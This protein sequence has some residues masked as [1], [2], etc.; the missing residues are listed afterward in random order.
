[1]RSTPA[2]VFRPSRKKK[3]RPGVGAAGVFD[4]LG[5]TGGDL[6][7]EIRRGLPVKVL[8]LLTEEL[9]VSQQTLLKVV[10]LPSA[11]LARR[12]RPPGRLSPQESDRVYRVAAAYRAALQL[13]EGD[14]ET[15]RRWMSEP[16][17]ALGGNTPI[18]HLDTEA[19]AGEVQDLIGRLEHGVIT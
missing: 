12:R 3:R 16:A 11:T 15:A 6:V 8:D 2:R 19:G 1:M 13:F 9:G 18:Q 17:K 10:A 5:L 4:R 14:A 7:S